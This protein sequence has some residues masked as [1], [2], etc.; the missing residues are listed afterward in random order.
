MDKTGVFETSIN[1][2]SFAFF[3]FPALFLYRVVKFASIIFS[4]S[5]FSFGQGVCFWLALLL[6]APSLIFHW[7]LKMELSC[8]YEYRSQIHAQRQQINTGCQKCTGLSFSFLH[9]SDAYL[10]FVSVQVTV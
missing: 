4:R 7:G 5:V 8:R 6:S 9:D 3:A 1:A 2:D 10:D